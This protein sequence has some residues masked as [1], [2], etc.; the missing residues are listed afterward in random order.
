[1]KKFLPIGLFLVSSLMS[2]AQKTDTLKSSMLKKLESIDHQG[3]N[4]LKFN[5]LF[6]SMGKPEFSYERIIAYNMGIGAAVFVGIEKSIA[7]KFGFIPY[8]RLYFGKKKASGFFIEANTGIV[9]L[10]DD[11]WTSNS[12]RPTRFRTTNLNLGV[13]T[14]AKLITRNGFFCEAYLGYG[15][16]LANRIGYSTRDVPRSG[17]IIGKRF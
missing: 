6:S 8:Y 1:M 11:Y 2:Y 10:E 14:G 3:N 16:L 5:L 4:E 9:T 13:A 7:F 15:K 17:I 12:N